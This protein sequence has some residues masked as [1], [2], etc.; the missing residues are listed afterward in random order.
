MRD[1]SCVIIGAG[2]AGISA[3]LYLKRANIPFVW[4]EKSM[5]GGKLVNLAEIGNYPGIQSI[6]GYD[7]ALKLLEST[8]ELGVSP[9]N[10]SVFSIEK[11]DNGFLLKTEKEEIATKTVIVATGLT[12]VPTIKGE[13]R[14][15]G[16]GVSYC[17]T[18]DGPMLKNKDAAISGKGD[19]VLEEALYLSNIVRKL[20]LLT[21]DEKYQ[22]DEILLKK[23]LEKGN[24]ELIEKSKIKEIIGDFRVNSIKYVKGDEENTLEISMIFPFSNEISAAAFLSSLNVETDKGFII[25]DDSCMS[26]VNGIFAA[27]DIVKKKLRQVVT[28]ASDGAIA[29]TGVASYLHRLKKENAK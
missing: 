21:E 29:A 4:L 7:L 1:T 18:C 17:A 6:S 20:Y 8:N 14:F 5:P 12:N 25:V 10:G 3:A 26:S 22:G 2:P 15:F 16:K 11:K 28:A 24:V 9:E 13:K 27:G 23:L 19:R